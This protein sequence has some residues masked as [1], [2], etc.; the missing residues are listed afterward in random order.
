MVNDGSIEP[1]RSPAA[2]SNAASNSRV[3][4]ASVAFGTFSCG[5]LLS[6]ANCGVLCSTQ[7]C[8]F[9]LDPGSRPSC[10]CASFP[11]ARFAETLEAHERT[12][13]PATCAPSIPAGTPSRGSSTTNMTAHTELRMSLRC[14]SSS[15][16]GRIPNAHCRERASLS[17]APEPSGRRAVDASRA[18][19]LPL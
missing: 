2:F 17:A 7:H 14:L 9:E 16:V 3:T 15:A 4:N 11:A 1:A 10:V 6:R 8:F 13:E 12:S 19:H 18:A 5:H